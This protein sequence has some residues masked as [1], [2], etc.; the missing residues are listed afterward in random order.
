MIFRVCLFL[1]MSFSAVQCLG[2]GLRIKGNNYPIVQRTSLAFTDR[3]PEIKSSFSLSFEIKL[4][5]ES[6]FGTVLRIKFA[7]P[8]FTY[9]IYFRTIDENRIEF[10][11]NEEGRSTLATILLDKRKINIYQWFRIRLMVDLKNKTMQWNWLDKGVSVP[12]KNLNQ[13]PFI[14]NIFFG[15]SD[16][17]IDIA[18]FALRKIEINLDAKSFV[19]PL[20]ESKGDKFH[21]NNGKVAG[22]VSN[23]VWLI[24]ESYYWRKR[25]SFRLSSVGGYQF[26]KKFGKMIFFT[27]DSIQQFDVNTGKLEVHVF[28]KPLP[29]AI[30]LGNSFMKENKLVLYEVNNLPDGD[31]SSVSIDLKTFEVNC[32]S[33]DQLERQLH[34]HT[35]IYY[36]N[37]NYLIFGG[38]GNQ[39]YNNSFL[40]M[41]LNRAVWDTLSV[42]GDHII[43]RYFTSSFFNP[44]NKSMY[45][46]GGMGNEAG[47]H[48]LGRRYFYDLYQLD[49]NSFKLKKIWEIDNKEMTLVPVKNLIYDQK[50]SFYTLMYSEYLSD[51]DLQLYKFQLNKP[52]FAV[53]GDSIPIKSE[54]IK[55]NANL[56]YYDHLKTFYAVTEVY[57]DQEL[58]SVITIYE[59]KTPAIALSDLQL[60]DSLRGNRYSWIYA[61]LGLGVV[62]VLVWWRKKVCRKNIDQESAIYNAIKIPADQPAVMFEFPIKNRI[63]LFGEFT[64]IDKYGKDISYLFSTRIRQLLV[65]FLTGSIKKGIKATN[66]S[67]A[68]WPDKELSASKNIRGVTINQL[69]KLFN[70]LDDVDLVYEDHTYKLKLTNC[71]VDYLRFEELRNEDSLSAELREIF[72]RGIF[73]KGIEENT[74]D[75]IKNQV[76]L[77]SQEVLR[78][79]MMVCF[80]G[81]R[82]DEAI[83]LA[84]LYFH[85][86]PISK[87]ALQVELRSLVK[88]G[89]R[90]EAR[91]RYE[92]FQRVY[93]D[94]ENEEFPI[95]FEQL[96]K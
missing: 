12:F 28:S 76:E 26:D 85:F 54:K 46:F 81:D 60:Y 48:T 50:G 64:V 53:L 30:Q 21:L 93:I 74:F 56:F 70:E 3:F 17:N 71:Y 7:Q 91:K 88:L 52:Q 40:S 9:S 84:R 8:E 35:G 38:F 78:R 1:L 43:P 34:H 87:N 57:D 63:H 45:V 2:N 89:N 23:P 94:W 47:D 32:L 58:N 19:I 65:L 83:A 16:Y 42:I 13:D 31:C 41:N 92:Q 75:Q 29:L 90:V 37:S 73:L 68:F 82:P 44:V 5:E 39:R 51:A 25:Q 55:T 95:S 86:D 10:K 77:H 67:E 15:K 72:K 69:R 36:D 80:H 22:K 96:I 61:I 59:L 4:L 6:S 20:N 49:L 14:D 11:L 18:D 79:F 27:K 24:N 33:T 66:I 62:A